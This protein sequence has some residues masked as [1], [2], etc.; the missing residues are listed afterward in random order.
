MTLNGSKEMEYE[1]LICLS[2]YFT[3]GSGEDLE[4]EKRQDLIGKNAA[5]LMMPCLRREVSL[6]TAQPETECVVLPPFH[7]NKMLEQQ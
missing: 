6:L 2:G 3:F 1:F 5:A 4:E 7:M